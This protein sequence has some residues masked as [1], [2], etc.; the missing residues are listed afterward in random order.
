MRDSADVVI[1]GG[2]AAGCAVAYYL[3]R[4]G[5][6]ARLIE[7]AGIGMQASG[8]SAGGVNPLHGLATSMQPLALASFQ[9]HLALWEEL[10]QVTGR[11][12][13]GHIIS[14]VKV[15]FDDADVPALQEECDV[16]AATPGFASHWL[17]RPALRALEPRLNPGVMRGVY[18]HGNGVVDSHLF[19]VL[20]AEAAQQYGASVQAGTVRG[21]QHAHGRVT[22]VVLDDGMLA[23]DTVVLAMGPWAQEAEAWLGLSIPVTPLK[24]EILRMV[25]QGPGLA[26]DFASP[27]VSLFSRGGQVWCGAT[28]ESCGFDKTP[29]AAARRSLLS[30]AITLLPAIASATLVQHTACLRPVTSDWLPIVG[31]APGWDNVYLVTGGE[32]KGILLSPAIGK[33]VADLITTGSTHLDITPC[34]PQR[35]VAVSA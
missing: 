29:S 22:G 28:Q 32:K 31:Q 11:D 15:A 24:G 8:Y 33:A 35:F 1:V 6:K 23:C 3:G 21:L 26:H 34:T 13:Q 2:G 18:L 10:Q 19:T 30:A 4:A 12:C 5:I 27:D 9:L 16:F 17:D 25:L 7:P 20:L 14:T